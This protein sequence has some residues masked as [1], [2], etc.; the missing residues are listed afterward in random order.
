M[1]DLEY[2]NHSNTTSYLSITVTNHVSCS[3]RFPSN[4]FTYKKVF[5]PS[6]ILAMD[7]R[8][9]AANPETFSL[10][11]LVKLS[12]RPNSLYFSAFAIFELFDFCCGLDMLGLV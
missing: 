8:H 6:R 3:R 1:I 2:S 11:S 7:F 5:Y 12:N 10:I 4:H 9:V